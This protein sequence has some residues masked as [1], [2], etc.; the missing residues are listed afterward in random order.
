MSSHEGKEFAASNGIIQGC[1]LSVLLLKFIMNTR[2]RSVKARTE[3]FS[4]D[5]EDIDVT[6]KI[7]ERF[8]RNTQQRQNVG[9]TKG[10]CTTQTALQPA[11]NFVER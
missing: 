6:L 5:S 3:A 9:I 1:L 10:S 4:K 11:R 8:T 2:A 7:T